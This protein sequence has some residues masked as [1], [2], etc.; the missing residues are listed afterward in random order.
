[1]NLGAPVKQRKPPYHSNEVQLSMYPRGASRMLMH[2]IK[3]II[4]NDGLRMNSK[5]YAMPLYQMAIIQK[6]I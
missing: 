1:M 2:G 4:L 5:K 6:F 3:A